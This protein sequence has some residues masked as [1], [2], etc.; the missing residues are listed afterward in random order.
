[1]QG[2][3][4]VPAGFVISTAVYRAVVDANDLTSEILQIVERESAEV[5]AEVLAERFESVLIPPRIAAPI[6]AA[7]EAI[8]AGSPVAVRS[9]ATTEDL[10][11]ASFAGQHESFLNVTSD[12]A[13]LGAVRACWASLWTARAIAYR[14]EMALDHG[15]AAMAVVV[16]VMLEATVS[17]VIFTANPTTGRRAEMVIEGSYG[18]GEAIVGGDVTPDVWLVDRER[19]AITNATPGSKTDMVV[20]TDGGTIHTPVPTDARARFCLADDTVLALMRLATDTERLLGG[21]PL[22]IEWVVVAGRCWLVQARPITNLPMAP[23][24]VVWLPPP[25]ATQLVRRQVVENM[26]GPLSP[27]FEDLYLHAGLDGGMDNLMAEMDLHI[28]IDAIV[29]RPL[30]VTSNGYGYCRY[31]LA[32]GWGMFKQ[33]PKM[34]Y[35][36]MTRMPRVLRT[37]VPRWE[38]GLTN[39]RAE[40]SRWQRLDGDSSN[41]RLY[42][43]IRALAFADATYWF[44]TTMMVGTAKIAEGLLALSLNA[45]KFRG[46]LTT[47]MFL[48]G[49]DSRT[50]AGEE[51]L[52][53]IAERIRADDGLREFFRA[54]PAREILPA[55][56]ALDGGEA[57]REKLDRY[58]EDFGH[59]VYDLDFAEPTQIEAPTPVLMGLKALVLAP[60]SSRAKQAELT[61]RQEKLIADTRARCGPLR[62]RVFDKSLGWAQRAGPYREEALFYMGAAWPTL[63]AIACQLGARFVEAGVFRAADDIYYLR[64]AELETLVSAE[65]SGEQSAALREELLEPIAER[66]R[67]RDARKGMHPPGRVPQ[68]VRIKFG[69]FDLTRLLE[70]FET[71]KRNLDDNARLNGFAVSPGTVLGPACLIR[72]T[73]DFERMRPDSILVCPTTTPAWTPLFSQAIGLVTDIGAVLAHGSI[74]AREYGIPAVLGCGN[75]TQR[76]RDGQ[77]IKVDGSAGIVELEPPIG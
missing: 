54:T 10:P 4:A 26:P 52:E 13:L 29:S 66:R 58:L 71:Q 34:M 35:M 47:G 38:K 32:P 59:Q 11:D 69:P 8:T 31:D 60:R 19:S 76:I 7:R 46:E 51:A 49:F 56:G 21:N 20:A 74:V 39:Y 68:D 16:Q 2:G 64:A 1:M 72:S 70:P 61:A 48:A 62:R 6:L 67:L 30:F 17:G 18:L 57:V 14:N 44:Y 22:D 41:A 40:I 24:D 50:I 75:A 42:E 55:L 3:I 28:D 15:N 37:L 5:A 73:R 65:R 27:L 36:T 43:G 9:S 33:F 23:E 53:A 63:R 77:M 45:R 25:G 12:D